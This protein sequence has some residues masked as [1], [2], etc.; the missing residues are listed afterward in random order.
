MKRVLK[1]DVAYNYAQK[2][3]FFLLQIAKNGYKRSNWVF[4]YELPVKRVV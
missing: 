4:H 2:N 3:K 1:K